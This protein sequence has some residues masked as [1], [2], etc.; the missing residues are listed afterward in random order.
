MSGNPTSP[1]HPAQNS[2]ILH[3]LLVSEWGRGVPSHT[4]VVPEAP[5]GKFSVDSE[6]R[7]ADAVPL[8]AGEGEPCLVVAGVECLY[9][10]TSE[11]SPQSYL[12]PLI[13]EENN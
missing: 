11:L 8:N 4:Q 7:F 1:L 2:S 3:D 12:F 10:L 9:P 5:P 13:A 6:L